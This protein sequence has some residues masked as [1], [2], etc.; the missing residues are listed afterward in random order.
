[1][2]R[3]EP[4]M[5]RVSTLH[6]QGNAL[7]YLTEDDLLYTDREDRRWEPVDRS[8]SRSTYGVSVTH[9]WSGPVPVPSTTEAS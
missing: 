9:L 1:M 8:K 6:K 2:D 3:C 5:C 4:E 7:F